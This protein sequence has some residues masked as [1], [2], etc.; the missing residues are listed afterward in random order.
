MFRG[1]AWRGEL[2]PGI[3]LVPLEVAEFDSAPAA[4]G[5]SLQCPVP[6]GLFHGSGLANCHLSLGWYRM[7]PR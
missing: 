3:D 4:P 6:A 1:L 5:Y 7:D 2:P